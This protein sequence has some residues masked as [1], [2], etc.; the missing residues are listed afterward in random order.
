MHKDPNIIIVLIA[1][2]NTWA[3]LYNLSI[4]SYLYFMK[5]NLQTFVKKNNKKIE[6]LDGWDAV[7]IAHN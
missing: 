1:S 7:P 2:N 4:I 3:F 6:F 5:T